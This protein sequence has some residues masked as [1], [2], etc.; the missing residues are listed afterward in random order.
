[1]PVSRCLKNTT[2][3]K[4][5]LHLNCKQDSQKSV[6]CCSAIM[7]C[8]KCTRV[9]RKKAADIETYLVAYTVC[10]HGHAYV[11]CTLYIKTNAE[12]RPEKQ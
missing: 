12:I 2:A 10:M 11:Y 4:L 1:M 6:Q 9:E 3:Q 5:K 7:T 8:T